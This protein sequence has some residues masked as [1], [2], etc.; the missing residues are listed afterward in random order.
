MR[1]TR[2]A[3]KMHRRFTT[4]GTKNTKGFRAFQFRNFVPFVNFVVR[5][6]F[7]KLLELSSD[8]HEK[9]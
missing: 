1:S 4:K 2:P 6:N 3:S 8:D 5:W 7:P 9:G